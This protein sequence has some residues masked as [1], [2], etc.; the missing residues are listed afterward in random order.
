MKFIRKILTR[1]LGVK[2]YL[3]L[4]SRV[5]IGMI[6]RGLLKEKYPEIHHL[7]KLLRPGMSVIDIGANLGYYST[8][9]GDLVGKEGRVIAIEPIP[10]FAEIFQKN[11]RRYR[12]ISIDNVALGA[13]SGRVKMSVPI[14]DGVV[15]H[16]LTQVVDKHHS[17]QKTSKMDY[18]VAMVS[19]DD[20]LK[21]KKLDQ[22]DYIKI[23]VEGYEQFIIPSLKETIGRYNPLIQIELSGQE[24]RENVFKFFKE[25]SYKGYILKDHSLESVD[26]SKL[27]SY[28][29]DFY[30]KPE[31]QT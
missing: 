4:I 28:T 5:Y 15:R 27:F 8:V 21:Q 16:G 29:Q 22:L 31:S 10:L 30:F 26:E 2:G 19:G 9:M 3:L 11:T 17:T 13:E 18:D 12:Q 25:N 14:V 20:L 6:R 23:D 1:V 24:N 7:K